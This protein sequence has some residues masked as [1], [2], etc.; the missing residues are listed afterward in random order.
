VPKGV[1]N[2]SPVVAGYL[3]AMGLSGNGPPS[4]E[5][6]RAQ[7]LTDIACLTCL[8][9]NADAEVMAEHV[10]EALSLG[11][12]VQDITDAIMRT[13]PHAGALAVRYGLA[14]ANQVFGRTTQIDIAD[15]RIA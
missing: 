15:R 5:Q 8:A 9:R 11:A 14:V 7:R 12:S 4:G 6:A 13:L 1:A 2:L 10:K 3:E